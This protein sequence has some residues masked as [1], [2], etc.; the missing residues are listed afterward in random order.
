[1]EERKAS[2]NMESTGTLR[3][4]QNILYRQ[5][6]VNAAFQCQTPQIA[7]FNFCEASQLR[8]VRL[9]PKSA[10]ATRFVL[11]CQCNGSKTF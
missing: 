4:Y 7:A 9:P 8:L 2:K 10:A 5:V 11:K 6:T 1:M 3:Y